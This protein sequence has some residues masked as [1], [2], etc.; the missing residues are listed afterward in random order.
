MIHEDVEKEK[1]NT[2]MDQTQKIFCIGMNKTGTTS[3]NRALEILGYRTIHHRKENIQLLEEMISTDGTPPILERYDAFTEAE[4]L[5]GSW[6]FLAERFPD[7]KYIFTTRNL[8]DW[9]TSRL[10]HVLHHRLMTNH[11]WREI[12]TVEDRQIYEWRHQEAPRYFKGKDNFL[13]INIPAG[14]GWDV[15]C[16]FLGCEVPTE[17][18]P[19]GNRGSKRLAEITRYYSQKTSLRGSNPP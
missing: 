9:L 10:I 12:N 13:M 15:L 5:S 7:A 8:E 17:P 19:W 16:P 6:Q 3:L 2:T 1:S 11:Q 4:P 14:D 18:F